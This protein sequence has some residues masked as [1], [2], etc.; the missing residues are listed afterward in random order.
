MAKAKNSGLGRGLDSLLGGYDV[1]A[2]EV[3]EQP[4]QV[5]ASAQRS[6]DASAAQAIKAQPQKKKEP[7]RTVITLNEEEAAEMA[8][9]TVMASPRP[10]RSMSPVVIEPDSVDSASSKNA[11]ELPLEK[12]IPNPNQ[13]RT[14]F[15][16]EELQ[17]LAASIQ[18]DGLLQPILVRPYGKDTYQIIAGERRW[19]ACNM[20]GLES[21]PVRIKEAED[22]EVLKLAIVENVQRTDLNPIEEAYGYKRL[23]EA[24]NLTQAQV[25]QEV[26]KGRSTIANALRL[27]DLPTLAQEMLFEE[28]ITAG[29]AR[30]ILSLDKPEDREKLT[31]KIIVDKLS[32]RETENIARLMK[33]N[34][35]DKTPKA[36]E[37]APKSFKMIQRQL[38]AKLQTPVK[39]KSVQ[40][41]NKIEVEFKDEED[42]ERLYKLIIGE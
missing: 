21:V 12:I 9:S 2:E 20:L 17:E 22:G 42:L 25:A 4:K 10:E 28:K 39:V 1:P 5:K 30:A 3:Q 8:A 13:P 14:N 33:M 11:F 18:R 19:Q 24:Y 31:N 40:G 36:K 16:Q 26:S 34:S 38:R 29:H 15:K 37:P 27:L 41:K 23:M 7:E 32:V 6:A 35:G